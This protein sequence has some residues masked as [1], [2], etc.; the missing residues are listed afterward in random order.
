MIDWKKTLEQFGYEEKDLP[1]TSKNKVIWKCD[2]QFCDAPVDIKEREFEF[3]YARKKHEKSL[4]NGKVD[5][6]QRCAHMHRRGKISEKSGKTH[7]PLPP[8]IS[9]ELTMQKYNYKPKDLAPW[10]R[11]KVILIAEDGSIHEASR[12]LLNTYKSVKETGHFKPISLW[13]K[14]RRTNIKATEET[15]ELMKKS[16]NMRRVREQKE[17]EDLIKKHIQEINKKVA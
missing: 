3:N 6:C 8:E 2:N 4:A 9:E 10:S 13:T 7:L 16:Q 5:V 17:R 1:P 14:E 15:K 12:A 11:K